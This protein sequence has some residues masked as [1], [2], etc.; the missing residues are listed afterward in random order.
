MSR[1]NLSSTGSQ[2]ELS[3]RQQWI[4]IQPGTGRILANPVLQ[5]KDSLPPKRKLTFEESIIP[6]LDL[7]PKKPQHH[8]KSTSL[9]PLPPRC[10]SPHPRS[11]SPLVPVDPS[12]ESPQG[13]LVSGFGWDSP[14]SV[15]DPY[16]TPFNPQP[17]GDQWDDHAVGPPP[18]R[19]TQIQ[20]YV[21]PILPLQTIPL[22]SLRC[23]RGQLLTTKL[24]CTNSLR[25]MTSSW[26]QRS[27]QYLLMLKGMLKPATYIFKEP[28]KV[29]VITPRVYNKFKASL[30]DT[31]YIR[32]HW[33]P[34][35]LVVHT[36]QNHADS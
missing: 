10:P 1:S 19:V 2:P 7:V 15:Y 14:G 13:S 30:S 26:R 35:S 11:A 24:R 29:C 3:A 22:H 16:D 23:C 8:D 9:P 28:V 31:S 6:P 25:K 21:R 5:A 34:D 4:H 17:H 18:P 12:P 27:M 36:A 32:G 33:R 20:T